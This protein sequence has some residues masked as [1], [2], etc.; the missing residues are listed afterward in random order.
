MNLGTSALDVA[1]GDCFW[2][3]LFLMSQEVHF[4]P[5][6][7]IYGGAA[8]WPRGLFPEGDQEEP[9]WPGAFRQVCLAYEEEFVPEPGSIALLGTGLAGLGGYAALRWRTRRR[10]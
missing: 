3:G 8:E 1:P 2:A 5:E 6:L 10:E 7:A 4:D 9:D